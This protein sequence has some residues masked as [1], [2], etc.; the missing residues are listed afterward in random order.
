MML[1]TLFAKLGMSSNDPDAWL[2]LQIRVALWACH[3]IVL[4]QA[5]AY[6]EKLG[7]NLRAAFNLLHD[8][9]RPKAK[10]VDARLKHRLAEMQMEQQEKLFK[11]IHMAYFSF[12]VGIV[13]CWSYLLIAMVAF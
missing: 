8:V 9:L 5:W 6:R 11:C 12:S 10:L 7:G 3:A 13:W 2:H 4:F 1:A